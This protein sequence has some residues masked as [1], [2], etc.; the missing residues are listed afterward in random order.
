MG[1]EHYKIEEIKKE[2]ENIAQI[3]YYIPTN[4]TLVK[5]DAS[6]SGLGATLQQKAGEG[7]W[8]PIAFASGYLI[9]QEKNL[10]N[11]LEL[12]AVVSSVDRFKH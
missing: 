9:S 7:N 5:C 8:M 12:L 1:E 4:N 6:H 10:T 11:A 3:N 2:L